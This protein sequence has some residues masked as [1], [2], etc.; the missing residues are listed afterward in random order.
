MRSHLWLTAICIIAFTA[1]FTN[2]FKLEND[3]LNTIADE[4]TD[5]KVTKSWEE[6]RLIKKLQSTLSTIPTTTKVVT[7]EINEKSLEND[8]SHSEVGKKD[9]LDDDYYIDDS[10]YDYENDNNTNSKE[11]V[12]SVDHNED[13]LIPTIIDKKASV[14]TS[15]SL[16]NPPSTTKTSSSKTTSTVSPN[17]END[18]YDN[19]EYDEDDDG[20]TDEEDDE[21]D[22]Y[23]E[24]LIDDSQ[25]EDDDSESDDDLLMTD[26][27]D[28]NKKAIKCPRDC[29]CDIN[30]NQFLVA[31]CSR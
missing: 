20:S 25:D 4:I 28:N 14:K 15:P 12:S 8:I 26:S 13:K 24:S 19:E 10:E 7:T 29:I 27:S 23:D 1:C 16:P 5:K 18:E 21:E 2:G 3:K 11:I 31:T 22:N 9:A 17:D 6:K 30:E